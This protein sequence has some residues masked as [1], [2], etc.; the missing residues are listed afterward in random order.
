M[1]K[2]IIRV[3]FSL[4]LVS[5]IFILACEK[6][7]PAERAGEKIDQAAEDV[8]DAMEDAADKMK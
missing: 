6:E 1:S 8:G 2:F 3:L 4:M 7:G 5:N